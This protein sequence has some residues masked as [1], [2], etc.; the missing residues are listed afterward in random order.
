LSWATAQTLMT[1]PR[2]L[3]LTTTS[4]GGGTDT[5]KNYLASQQLPYD[6]LAIPKEGYV[7]A[8]P[9]EMNSQGKYNMIVFPDGLIS[10]DYNGQF[11]SALTQA[12]F[13]QLGFYEKTYGAT[14]ILFNIYPSA[15]YG[16]SLLN[17]AA[18]VCCGTNVEQFYRWDTNAFA[19]LNMAGL[20]ITSPMSSIG[21]SHYP[22]VITN[23]TT[24][25]P[26]VFADALS[27]NYSTNSVIGTSR[28]VD[29][30]N[31][32]VFFTAIGS[33]SVTSQTLVRYSVQ[34]SLQKL[35]ALITP[36][37]INSRILLV[38]SDNSNGLK[39][40][41]VTLDGLGVPYTSLIIPPTGLAGN[42]TL[43]S[44]NQ[45]L[46]SL[47]VFPEGE[48]VYQDSTGAY[49]SVITAAQWAQLAE[50]ELKYKVRRVMM[51]IYPNSNYYASPQNP[52]NPG[53]CELGVERVL[54]WE[55]NAM[56]LAPNAGLVST[57][58][59]S[60]SGLYHYPATLTD[61]TIARPILS[62]LPYASQFPSKGVIATQLSLPDGRQQLIFFISFGSF[63]SSSLL[64]NH[65]WIFWGM[66]GT[67]PGFRRAYLNS[68][69]DDVF[70][71]TSL[72][73]LFWI[74]SL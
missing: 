12:Q 24:N 17:S 16:V 73:I 27:P 60:A 21:L 59:L 57:A 65:F 10:Y 18:P 38:A 49:N 42:F 3:I 14:R 53:C 66:R 29:G 67:F 32:L 68:Q 1:N 11:L 19:N 39:A 28:L 30:R 5:F 64:M 8:L 50:Y 35:N 63:S 6:I 72:V 4:M 70:L 47:I 13:S 48:V 36:L 25:K 56:S 58:T 9:L 51:N 43:T 26:I 44:G 41:T 74:S 61:T 37:V 31:M 45:G 2:V 52:T 54:V 71:D 20:S 40:A 33:W 7:G 62:S 34:W 69:I 15:T 23:T 46:Y 55:A 22:A